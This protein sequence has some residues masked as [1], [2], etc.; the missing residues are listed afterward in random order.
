[1]IHTKKRRPSKQLFF[2][3]LGNVINEVMNTSLENI[4]KNAPQSFTTPS[5]NV[6]KNEDA[7]ELQMALPGFD[8][9]EVSIKID[10]GFLTIASDRE[11]AKEENFRLREFNFGK[12][13]RKFHLPKN[14][15]KESIKATFKNGILQIELAIKPEAKPKT[16]S[17]K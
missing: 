15:D 17:I 9:K 5:V 8:K 11:S 14:V 6:T 2:P 7:Y 1:M 12:F 16:I 4:V 3:H 13:E 10:R